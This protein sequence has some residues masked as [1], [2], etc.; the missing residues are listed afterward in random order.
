VVLARSVESEKTRKEL[1]A[2]SRRFI[3]KA[4]AL[5]HPCATS[6]GHKKG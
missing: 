4:H 6:P 2:A 3:D 5:E 1:L